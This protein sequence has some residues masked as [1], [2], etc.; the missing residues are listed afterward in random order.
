MLRLTVETAADAERCVSGWIPVDL[1][2][3][4][5]VWR[6]SLEHSRE[7]KPEIYRK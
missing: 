1:V 4:V 2:V 3:E 5:D 6:R 7:F